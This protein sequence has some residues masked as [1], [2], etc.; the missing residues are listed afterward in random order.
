[1]S[2]I[3]KPK[4]VAF[5][6]FKGGVGK[7]FL[8]TTVATRLKK[9]G[10]KVLFYDLDPQ[11]TS[12]FYFSRIDEKFKPDE[13]ITNWTQAPEKCL[14]PDI[15]IIDCPPSQDF[16]PPDDFIIV[17][18]TYSTADDLHS[19]RKVLELEKTH[20]VIKVINQFNLMKRAD[21]DLLEEFKECCVVTTNSAITNSR[22]KGETLYDTKENGYKKAQRQINEVVKAILNG[23]CET[24]DLEKV[25]R[26]MLGLEI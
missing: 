22:N 4:F 9:D 7:T 18:P 6:N 12:S 21:K 20:T 19:Y 14:H 3:Q 23:K 2:N 13:V 11:S 16:V 15:V 1:M 5:F 17:A 10:W 24:M 26:I 25:K 8:S